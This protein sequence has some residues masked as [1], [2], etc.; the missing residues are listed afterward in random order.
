MSGAQ[1]LITTVFNDWRQ[2]NLPT[3]QESEAWE[4]FTS[5]LLLRQYDANL[6]EVQTG[7]VDGGDDGGIDSVFT[8]IGG[9]IAQADHQ[10][11]EDQIEARK[12]PEGIE[13]TL[14]IAQSKTSATFK[15]DAVTRLHSVLPRALDLSKDLDGLKG[16]LNEAVREQ[17]EVFRNAYRNLL[18]RRPRVSVQVV[19]VTRGDT[20]TIAENVKSRATALRADLDALMPSAEVRVDFLGADE[21]W[22]MFDRRSASTYQLECSELILSGA[23]YI[24]LVKLS[25]YARLILDDDDGV[26]RHLFDAN[27]RD[28]QGDVAVNKE[29]Y[30]SLEDSAG[31]EFWWLNN[32][33]TI[34]CDEAH[35][36]GKTIA[37]TNIQ[38]VNGL[39]TSHNVARWFGTGGAGSHSGDP[40]QLLVRII[41]ASDDRVRDKIIRATN[42]QTPVADASLRATD[43]VQR[44][45]EKYF[46]SKGLYYDRRRGFHRNLG[47]DPGKIISIPY[48]GQAVFSIAY[49]GP[50][51]ARGKPNSL[52]AVDARY[53]RAFDPGADIEVYHLCALIM[54]A[55]DEYLHGIVN[56]MTYWERKHISYFVAF[57]YVTLLTGR[58]PESWRDLATVSRDDFQADQSTLELA[59]R[60]T[61]RALSEFASENGISSTDATKRQGLTTRLASTIL[62]QAE[63]LIS[64]KL[65]GDSSGGGDPH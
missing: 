39:Q 48:L 41:V 36:A 49:G 40:R 9:T 20:G 61:L 23:S 47:R 60:A 44:R 15:Q 53:K 37:M 42:R 25:N 50:E 33:V 14:I 7:I 17:L 1:T 8:L 5:W 2:T 45:I 11:V 32:G 6:D 31:P 22:R 51:V 21:L 34:L 43:E 19:A 55:V 13:I 56:T 27:V 63:P 16:E 35:G 18:P 26:R 62:G 52:L 57:A 29:I 38:I 4:I 59:Y 3:T 24:A 54:Q 10:F 65:A 12:A 30:S 28:F 46:E 58:A 64:P